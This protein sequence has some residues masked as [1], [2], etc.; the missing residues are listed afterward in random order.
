M[1]IHFVGRKK[2]RNRKENET[3]RNGGKKRE[4]VELI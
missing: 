4:H 3:E 2:T 1:E